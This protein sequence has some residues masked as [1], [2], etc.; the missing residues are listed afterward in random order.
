[1][2]LRNIPRAKEEL[3]G[4]DWVVQ[5]PE[6][7]PGNWR[8]LYTQYSAESDT[9]STEDD[10]SE[11]SQAEGSSSEGAGSAKD[12]TRLPLHL[13]IGTGKG[14]F[15]MEKAAREPNVA[16]VGLEKYSSVLLRLLEKQQE[17]AL[18]NL[19]LIRG[20]AELIGTYF[21]PGEVD[22][23]YLNFSD[24]W[25]KDRHA[26]RRLPSR[27]FLDRYDGILAQD[28]TIEFKTDQRPLFDFAVEQVAGS[29]FEI[30]QLTYDLHHD[31]S[32]NEGNIMTE[33]EEKF[34]KKGNLIC[35]YI[36]RKRG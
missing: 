18:P 35:K 1:M 25:P 10:Q 11:G 24:P 21:A 4:S 26:N 20:E 3:A 32:M 36:L 22:R 13:E 29:P 31:P 8:S 30:V 23:I 17:A 28:G 14:R 34:S 2:R 27:V 12:I 33:Y 19:R 7:M 9:S 5:I 16:F 15:I 6:E